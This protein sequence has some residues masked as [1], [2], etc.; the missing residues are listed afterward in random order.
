MVERNSNYF[1][2][3]GRK[4]LNNSGPA[5]DANLPAAHNPMSIDRIYYLSP[6]REVSIELPYL[7]AANQS[8]SCPVCMCGG[9]G[10]SRVRRLILSINT[11]EMVIYSNMI[12]E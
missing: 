10:R 9:D 12:L 2:K 7:I 5:S 3:G 4:V 8:I 1:N 6:Y 11:T